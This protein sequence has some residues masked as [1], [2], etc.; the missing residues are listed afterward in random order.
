MYSYT[1]GLQ[2]YSFSQWLTT[3]YI[4]SRENFVIQGNQRTSIKGY[5]IYIWKLSQLKTPNPNLQQ[6]IRLIAML[7][8]EIP[9]C[10]ICTR[11]L[12]GILNLL[13][14]SQR[15]MV[16]MSFVRY[17]NLFVLPYMDMSLL[18]VLFYT[19]HYFRPPHNFC[20]FICVLWFFYM[21]LSF[22]PP[23]IWFC[24]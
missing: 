6:R 1:H 9:S 17:S 16:R 5:I 19:H 7:M 24:A 8:L 13:L 18:K 12:Q 22:Y 11:F 3:K 2:Q 20:L 23:L 15:S 21:P 14:S 4:C 10:L